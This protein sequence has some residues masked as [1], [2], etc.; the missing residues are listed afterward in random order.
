MVRVRVAPDGTIISRELLKSSGQPEWD[1]AVINAIDKA[2]MV[3]RDI[4]NRVPPVI[5]IPWT[6]TER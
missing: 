2:G 1:Q 3:P 5:D 6:A 4:D